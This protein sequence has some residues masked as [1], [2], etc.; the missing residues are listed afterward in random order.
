MFMFH[1]EV[2][3]F[4][5]STLFYTSPSGRSK[6]SGGTGTERNTSAAGLC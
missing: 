5:I 6:K 3:L 4:R 2:L 1:S